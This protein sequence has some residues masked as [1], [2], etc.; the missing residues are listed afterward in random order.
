[1]ITGSQKT[2]LSKQKLLQRIAKARR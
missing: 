1:V 2:Y